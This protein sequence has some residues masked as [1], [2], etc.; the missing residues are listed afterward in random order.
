MT[1]PNPLISSFRNKVLLPLS[2]SSGETFPS[3]VASLL[4]RHG[5]YQPPGP[6]VET[7]GATPTQR[8]KMKEIQTIKDMRAA[9]SKVR[10]DGKT[11]AF[12]PTMGALHRGHVSLIERASE[13]ADVVVVSSFI[14]P[15]QF[16][17]KTDFEKYP[18]DP[19]HDRETAKKAG[20]QFFFAPTEEEMYPH[21]FLTTVNVSYL[22]NL[23]EGEK[24]PGHFRGVCTIVLKL[25]NIVTPDFLILG[26]KDAQ[27]YTI[28]QHMVDDL[29]IDIQVIGVPT[30]RDRDGVALSS[31][32]ALLS[33]EDRERARCMSRALKRVHFLVK[34]QG[35]LHSGELMQAIRS[36]IDGAGVELEYAAIVNRTTLEPID[37]V[38]RGGT[39]IL[40][41]I[42]VGG[43]RLIDNTRI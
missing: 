43:V 24:R 10:K 22:S 1:A 41:A 6:V 11:V 34:Q 16:N 5:G 36:T 18:R 23:L 7:D 37:H 21:G 9:I 3:G 39:Y 14:N 12:V 35:I 26:V 38:M 31:R 30:A 28:I 33:R 32:N 40:L 29:A 17:D 2:P 4:V 19:K 8:V 42:R 15:K 13:L 25:L 27:Q 20:V